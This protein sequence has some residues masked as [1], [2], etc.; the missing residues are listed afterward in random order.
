MICRFLFYVGDKRIIYSLI[1]PRVHIVEKSES[2]EKL[3]RNCQNKIL[4]KILINK[5]HII[6]K[7]P[8]FWYQLINLNT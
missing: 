6:H 4:I 7:L 3:H 2:T 8:S 5:R 1:E